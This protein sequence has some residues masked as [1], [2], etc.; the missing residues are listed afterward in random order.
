MSPEEKDALSQK[1]ANISKIM[2]HAKRRAQRKSLPFDLTLDYLQAIAP[3]KCPIFKESLMWGINKKEDSKMIRPMSPSLDRVVP[4]KGYIR[5]NVAWMSVKANMIKSNANS[6]EL[7]LVADWLKIKE[8]EIDL[9]GAV[10]PPSFLDSA[11]T[12]I[13]APSRPR[14]ITDDGAR[15]RGGY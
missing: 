5:G 15:E 2:Y 9:Y 14:I 8:K 6:E 10:R 3:D 7:Y 1:R 12:Y 11:F 4:S 13:Q